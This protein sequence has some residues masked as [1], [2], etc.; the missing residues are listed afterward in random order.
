MTRRGWPGP[1]TSQ[2]EIT[3]DA[4]WQSFGRMTRVDRNRPTDSSVPA[5]EFS[6]LFKQFS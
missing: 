2:A 1:P 5:L 3:E 4:R 6:G